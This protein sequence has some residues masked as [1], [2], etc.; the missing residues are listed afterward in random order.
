[1]KKFIILS[2]VLSFTFGLLALSANAAKPS[3]YGLKEGELISAIFSDDPDVYIINDSGY[4]RLFLNPTIFNFYGHLGGFFN[5]KLVPTEVRD[6]FITSGLFRNCETNDPKVYGV[7]IDGEDTGKLHWV[8][9]SSDNA[10]I[11]DQ[12]FFKK[13]FCINNNEFNWYPKGSE[14]KA[15]KDVPAYGRMKEKET[16][17]TTEK[18]A[19]NAATKNVGKVT[20]CHYPPGNSTAYETITVNASALKTHLGHGDTVGTCPSSSDAVVPSTPTNLIATA[21]SPT[22]IN[23]SWSSSTDNVGVS[24]YKIYRSGIQIATSTTNSYSNIGLTP[25]TTYSYNVSAYDAAGNISEQSSSVSATTLASSSTDTIAPSTPTNLTATSISSSQIN[26]SWTASTDNVG[27]AGYRI[28]RGGVQIATSTTNSYSNTGL[29]ALSTYSYTVIAYDAVGNASGQSN[30]ASATALALQPLSYCN[31]SNYTFCDDFEGASINTAKWQN[32]TLSGTADWQQSGGLA[33][34]RLKAVSIPEFG[35]FEYEIKVKIDGY[36][37]DPV[38]RY[39][40]RDNYY[41]FQL[42]TTAAQYGAVRAHVKV[43]G[44][45]SVA[46]VVSA[47]VDAPIVNNQWFTFKV[48]GQ[49]SAFYFYV[50]NKF[51]GFFDDANNTYPMGHIGFR[52]EVYQHGVRYDDIRIKNTITQSLPDVA[53]PTISNIQ[54]VSVTHNSATI[55]WI[56]NKNSDSQ[57]E[58]GLTTSYG[59]STALNASMLTGHSV[60]LSGLN[61]AT[62]YHYRVKSKDASSNLAISE[63]HTLTTVDLAWAIDATPPV[64]SN[65]Q[66]SGGLVFGTFKTALSVTTD[67]SATCK[68]S[69]TNGV[70]YNSMTSKLYTVNGLSHSAPIINLQSNKS[71]SYYIKCKDSTGNA[72]IND[73]TISFSVANS[74]LTTKAY[75][76]VYPRPGSG[77]MPVQC[78]YTN[79]TTTVRYGEASTINIVDGVIQ[80]GS[81]GSM[82]RC[83]GIESAVEPNV[84]FVP[85]TTYKIQA[86]QSGLPI[87]DIYTFTTWPLANTPV[88]SITFPVL[89]KDA[90]RIEY[91]VDACSDSDAYIYYGT[92]RASVEGLTSTKA[93]VNT[94]IDSDGYHRFSYSFYPTDSTALPGGLITGL[95]PGTTYYVKAVQ[96]SSGIGSTE[97]GIVTFTTP[98]E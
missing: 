12:D 43:N 77:R 32:I 90:V 16:I 67:E 56:T 95:T 74:T 26:L 57:L 94:Y 68:Y 87:T 4:K 40:D 97:S 6:A 25:S 31:D 18:I 51:I 7:D 81:T 24:G 9:V 58:Y 5:V 29:S 44:T 75:F 71:Y 66:P 61:P 41:L 70:S 38:F 88:F 15:I 36:P 50:D 86:F 8:N 83:D 28:Y 78:V 82:N 84:T 64:I 17:S 27:V 14:F 85:N 13:V 30:S 23:L 72:N 42:N 79:S 22:Q 63:D 49:G 62:T 35:N 60:S 39:Q 47:T 89:Y 92:D 54:A 46:K 65:G 10:S 20:I 37:A 11:E 55:T 1:M 45:W 73:Y 52:E 98:S 34:E 59:N 2:V 76:Y 53:P 48:I 93:K 91:E 33:G 19:D 80:N 69:I 21:I 3:D 96:N